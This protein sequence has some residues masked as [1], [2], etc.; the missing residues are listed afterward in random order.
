MCAKQHRDQVSGFG[1]DRL[2]GNVMG[3]VQ[4]GDR[5]GK[6]ALLQAAASN[7]SALMGHVAC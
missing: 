3:C 6:R 2:I 1:Q 4:L 5:A 7:G